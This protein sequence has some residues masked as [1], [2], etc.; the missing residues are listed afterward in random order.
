MS[1]VLRL[2]DKCAVDQAWDEYAVHMRRAMDDQRLLLD[3]EW[4]EQRAVLQRR[5]DRLYLMQE[6]RG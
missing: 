3:R 2:A 5:F 4:M 6:R 1:A